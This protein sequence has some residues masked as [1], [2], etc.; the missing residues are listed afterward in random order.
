MSL[1]KRIWI[2]AAALALACG[3]LHA[4]E[5]IKV[6]LNVPM[7]GPFA[8]VGQ[9]YVDSSRLVLDAINGRGGVLSGRKL[10]LEVFDN[11]GSPQEAL[12]A[13]KRISD[14]RI[15]F[16]ISSG[17]SHITVPLSEAIAR[18][19]A[20]EPDNRLL[21]LVEPGDQELTNE[22]CSFWTFAFMANPQIK[23]E[24]LV[25]Y[26]ARRTDVKRVY[27]I[28]QDYQFG[29][30]VQRFAREA[31]IRKRPDIAIVGDDLHPLGKVKDF[32]PYVAKIRAAKADTVITG[33]WAADMTLLVRAAAASGLPATFY[34]YYGMGLGAPTAM[35]PAAIDKVNVIWRW[36]PNLP[37]G[38][39]RKL[40]DEYKRRF[41]SD[42]Y[43]MSLNNLFAMLVEAMERAGSTEAIPVARELEDL[44]IRNSM[45]E[46]WMRPDDHQLFEP[47]Y[48]ISITRLNGRDVRYNLENTELGTTTAARIEASEM[49]LPTQCRMQRPALR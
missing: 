22:K 33:N 24:S 36:H 46:A 45:G 8:I 6:A 30:Q 15:P 40:A 2:G 4:A 1:I 47:L 17:G 13:L 42:Y 21:F 38:A 10:E 25:S 3:R 34:T 20:R 28:N 29:H 39:E 43:S 26:I 7:S 5:P 16:L 35:G 27:L 31:L 48:I 18:H 44:R 11:K 9:L 49:M 12:L 37:F 14:R 19:N 32:A 41:K 23:M